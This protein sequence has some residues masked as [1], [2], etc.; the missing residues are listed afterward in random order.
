MAFR[1]KPRTTQIIGLL[2]WIMR[3]MLQPFLDKLK[4]RHFPPHIKNDSLIAALHKSFLSFGK[5]KS[6]FPIDSHYEIPIIVRSDRAKY[7]S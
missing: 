4:E 3:T 1:S 2:F 7:Q 5:R 6:C